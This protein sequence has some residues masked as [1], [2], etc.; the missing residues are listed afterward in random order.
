MET[1]DTNQKPVET[2][3]QSPRLEEF[4]TRLKLESLQPNC[5]GL[6][7]I[8][9][10]TPETVDGI[11]LPAFPCAVMI[12]KHKAADAI[13]YYVHFSDNREV[14]LIGKARRAHAQAEALAAE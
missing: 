10:A 9:A 2:Q 3:W 13:S 6:V 11:D 7:F 5:T 8:D 12:S 1:T 4:H 14:K